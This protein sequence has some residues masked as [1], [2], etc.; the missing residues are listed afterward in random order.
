MPTTGNKGRRAFQDWI[1]RTLELCKK[2]LVKTKH[3]D[4]VDIVH[5]AIGSTDH[6]KGLVESLSM[7]AIDEANNIMCAT[8][9]K[10]LGQHR[11]FDGVLTAGTKAHKIIAT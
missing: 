2:A 8:F 7:T 5:C 11:L 10:A 3:P 1:L 4:E 6:Y 9:I